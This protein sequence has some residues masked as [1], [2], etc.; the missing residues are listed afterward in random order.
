[1]FAFEPVR[2][3]GLASA[4]SSMSESVSA[5]RVEDEAT[6]VGDEYGTTVIGLYGGNLLDSGTRS[7]LG[8]RWAEVDSR[9][10]FENALPERLLGCS[11]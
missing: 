4:V 10:A 7:C 6:T 11:H 5:C 9:L 8:I 1:M 3:V 2:A